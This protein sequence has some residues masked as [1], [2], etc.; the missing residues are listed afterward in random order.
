MVKVREVCNTRPT[1]TQTVLA[2]VDEAVGLQEIDHP[3]LD[4]GLKDFSLDRVTEVTL[5]ESVVPHV[6]EETL[7]WGWG[8]RPQ[9]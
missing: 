2:R 1:L 5:I 4:D 7:F 3:V 8:K 6:H 9:T